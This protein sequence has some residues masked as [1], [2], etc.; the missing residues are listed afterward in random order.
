MSIAAGVPMPQVYVQDNEDYINAFAA[1]HSTKDAAVTVTR[2][3]MTKLSRDELQ[4]VI[5]HEFSH[6]LNGDM[7]LNIR[8]I[9]ILFG[10]FCIA[11]IGR[12]LMSARGRNSG[13][14]VMIGLL[15]LAIGSLGVLFGRLI[16]AAVSRQREFL[17]ESARTVRRAPK[18]RRLRF[19]HG[20]AAR[21]R[22]EPPVFCQRA[23]RI[24]HGSD[25]HTPAVG[26][27]Y[28]RH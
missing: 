27:A 6:I 22:R 2:N 28:P 19:G 25:G 16:Q 7:R 21:L 3:C 24:V 1:G 10:I 8:L 5:G 12:I 13:G 17:A 4:G 9:G 20:L 23:H 26:D 15:L 18:N 11:T 14:P